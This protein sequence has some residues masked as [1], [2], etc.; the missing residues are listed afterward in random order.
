[1]SSPRISRRKADIVSGCAFVAVLFLFGALHLWWP[2]I[3]LPFGVALTLRQYLRG[4]PY[5]VV[6]TAVIF[7]A[8]FFNFLFNIRWN[9]LIPVLLVLAAVYLVYREY[10]C[11]RERTGSEKTEDMKNEL[12]D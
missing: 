8:L 4:R 1:M 11:Y 12:E 3:I 9:F 5:D 7:L 6:L 2:W 10:M